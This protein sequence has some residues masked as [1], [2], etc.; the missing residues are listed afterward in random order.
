MASER[1][2]GPLTVDLDGVEGLLQRAAEDEQRAREAPD[3]NRLEPGS[4]EWARCMSAASTARADA[5]RAREL[6]FR[7]S[8]ASQERGAS[9]A[10]IVL[11]AER[12]REGKS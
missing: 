11:A 3:G 1:L 4:I 2:A 5:L 9:F 7:L 6:R 8:G 12:R 10:E